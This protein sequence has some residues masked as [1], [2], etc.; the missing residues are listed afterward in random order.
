MSNVGLYVMEMECADK[1]EVICNDNGSCHD[2]KY[3]KCDIDFIGDESMSRF[4][5]YFLW[6]RHR[7]YY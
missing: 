2:V 5:Y 7:M 3:I 6:I 1:C 4:K